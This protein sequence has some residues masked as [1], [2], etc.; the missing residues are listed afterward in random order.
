MS[1]NY[2]TTQ[3]RVEAA[4]SLDCDR[5]GKHIH[6]EDSME[7][8]ERLELQFMGGFGSVWGDGVE[9]QVALCQQCGYELLK[10]YAKTK[11]N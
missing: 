6:H 1:M 9:V 4:D 11:I 2:R 10:P 8:Q 5:C 7:F 3:V